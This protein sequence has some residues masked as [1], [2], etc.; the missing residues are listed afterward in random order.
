MFNLQRRLV[1]R[2]A[3]VNCHDACKLFNISTGL[4]LGLG[5]FPNLSFLRKRGRDKGCKLYFHPHLSAKTAKHDS[6]VFDD[7]MKSVT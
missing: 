1:C 5:P 2:L 7:L 6:L 3:I 4:C